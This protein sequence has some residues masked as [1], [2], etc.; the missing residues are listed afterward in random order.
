MVNNLFYDAQNWQ[1]TGGITPNIQ[2]CENQTT[3]SRTVVSCEHAGDWVECELQPGNPVKFGF[4][5]Q[6]DDTLEPV[7]PEVFRIQPEI[8]RPLA[9]VTDQ[10]GNQADFVENEL[11]VSTNDVVLLNGILNRWQGEVISIFDPDEYALDILKKQY[12]VRIN[13]SLADA[14]KLKD[15]LLL[16]NPESTGSIR[17]SSSSGLGLLAAGADEAVRG[18]SVGINWVGQPTSMF[19]DDISLEAPYGTKVDS[20][21]YDSNVFT[22]PPTLYFY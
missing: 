10:F 14:D 5:I 20:T 17:V 22:W 4:T 7:L 9:T 1:R 3:R 12:L 2:G 16:L 18:I 11:W 19:R 8:P 15:D 13:T 21:I 6:L